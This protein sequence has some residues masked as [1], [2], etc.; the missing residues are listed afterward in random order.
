MKKHFNQMNARRCISVAARLG[1]IPAHHKKELL[2]G[3]HV[4]IDRTQPI[5]LP[6]DA[7]LAPPLKPL[8]LKQLHVTRE[9]MEEMRQLRAQDPV[10][11]TRT[12]LAAKFD[13]SVMFVAMAAPAPAEHR[14]SLDQATTEAAE[15]YGYK[16]RQIR[17]N[18][19]RRRELW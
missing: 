12:R 8:Q 19:K 6:Q 1:R 16:R 2:P 13:C 11:W 18:R 3:G 14:R 4:L 7:P 9:Q 10:F 17:L 15:H 5:V